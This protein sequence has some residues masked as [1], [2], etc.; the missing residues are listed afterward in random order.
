[1][2]FPGANHSDAVE[3]AFDAHGE[4][5]FPRAACVLLQNEINP[6]A[7]RYAMEHAGNATVI[8][9]PSPLPP[10]EELRA[11]PW[12][13]VAWLVI[14]A[15]E[16]RGVL[17]ALGGLESADPREVLERLVALPVLSATGIVCTL[18]ARGV[19]AAVR[20]SEAA[21]E[22]VTVAAA[23]L[24]GAVRDTTGAG[25]CFTGYFAQGVVCLCGPGSPRADEIKR[26]LE[27]CVVV[28]VFLK[29]GL[30]KK[31][32]YLVIGCGDVL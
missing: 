29:F 30:E 22:T 1:M 20:G 15:E 21:V 7:T 26:V 4:G 18:G 3:R 14:N 11:L 31:S 2:L 5:W 16:A 23:A 8:F 19:V 17:A 25:D 27:I 12:A 9:N 10:P 6:H 13:R 24:R 32:L 28:S